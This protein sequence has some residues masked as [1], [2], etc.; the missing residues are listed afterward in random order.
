MAYIFLRNGNVLHHFT[1]G[2]LQEAGTHSLWLFISHFH[3]LTALNG[4]GLLVFFPGS[5]YL[6]ALAV[7][8]VYVYVFMIVRL[9]VN[10]FNKWLSSS[11]VK[12]LTV[13]DEV[14]D[15]NV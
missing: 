15:S 1:S 14:A 4:K 6:N 2:F 8:V 13:S 3:I 7:L 11:S 10:S 5:Y 9:S 12:D